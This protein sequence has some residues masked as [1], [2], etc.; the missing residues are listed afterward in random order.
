[1]DGQQGLTHLSLDMLGVKSQARQFQESKNFEAAANLW[2]QFLQEHPGNADAL[3]ELG[4]IALSSG[5]YENALQ[6]FSR[7]LELLPDLVSAKANCGVALRH[8]N[9]FEEAAS[10]L[11][12][13]ASS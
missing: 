2:Q 8:L 13:A 10:I 3:I 12:T 7:A 1:M 5:Q 6:W 9:R 4:R 11:K